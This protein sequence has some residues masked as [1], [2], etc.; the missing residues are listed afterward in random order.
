MGRLLMVLLGVALFFA[1]TPA[2]EIE[3][4]LL[5]QMALLESGEQIEVLVVL[6][7]QLD[8]EGIIRTIK[9]KEERWRHTVTS[10]KALAERSQ[11][12]LL[13]E[14]EGHQ[15]AGRVGQI[16]PFWLVNAVYCEA[17]PEVVASVAARPEVWVVQWDRIATPNALGLAAV[18]SEGDVTAG[19]YTVEWNVRKVKADSVWAVYGYTGDGVVVGNI[20]TG[21]DYTHPDLAGH[22]WT[23]PSYPN[24]GW[25]FEGNNN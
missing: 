24:H 15:R 18:A 8:G 20:D 21:C 3:P 19:S 13:A 7:E 5:D 23:D 25:N 17:T 11:A 12:G 10:A 2:A 16:I 14:L 9:D 6:T 1:A 22:M 4:L